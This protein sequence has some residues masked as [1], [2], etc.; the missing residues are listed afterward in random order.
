M[1]S[2]HFNIA[3]LSGMVET[4]NLVLIDYERGQFKLHELGIWQQDFTIV[5]MFFGK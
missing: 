4:E 2:Q 3:Q 1:A 5:H